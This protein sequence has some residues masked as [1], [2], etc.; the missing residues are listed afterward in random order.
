MICAFDTLLQSQMRAVSGVAAAA[1]GPRATA[2]VDERNSASAR[3]SV[4]GIPDANVCNSDGTMRAVA[5]DDGAGETIVAHDQLLVDAARRLAIA[6]DLVVFADRILVAHHRKIDAHH[7][8][9][10]RYGRPEIDRVWIAAAEPIGEPRGLLPERRNQPVHAAAVL[11]ALAHGKHA[12]C[13]AC[14]RPRASEVVA[15]DDAAIDFEAGVGGKLRVGPDAGGDHDEIAFQRS[16]VRELETLDMAVSKNGRRASGKVSNEAHLLE[17]AAKNIAGARIELRLHQMRH[18]MND[19]GF[20]A[21]VQ[22]AAGRFQPQQPSANH[23]GAA[24]GLRAAHDALAIVQRAKHEHTLLEDAVLVAHVRERRNDGAA[25]G[26]D[27]QRVVSLR[28]PAGRRHRSVVQI[29]L[30]DALAGM[31]R[32]ALGRVPRHR[33]DEDVVGLVAAREH[34]REQDAVVIAA[35]L[36]AKHHDVEAARAPAPQQIVDKP[37]ARHTVAD[38]DQSLFTH[39]CRFA[40]RTP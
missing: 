37:G 31:K 40:R 38:D 25:A 36:V 15:D 32:D 21:P 28:Q 24:R 33:I 39:R 2:G 11:G 29:N 23:S 14:R 3:F 34:A 26:G 13:A 10:G 9:L 18:Q 7:L 5:E 35:G 16:A 1:S 12:R 17:L 20:Q 19:V 4:S 22:K 8:E 30:L 6:D 27:D